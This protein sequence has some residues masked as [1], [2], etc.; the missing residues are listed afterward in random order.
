MAFRWEATAV[1]AAF[2]PLLLKRYQGAE[3]NHNHAFASAVVAV[4]LSRHGPQLV[5]GA[6]WL[7][8]APLRL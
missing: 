1:T 6:G 8:R 5:R 2:A 4:V 3:I 7:L